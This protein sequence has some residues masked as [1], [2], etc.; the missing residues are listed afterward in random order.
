V[1]KKKLPLKALG[2]TRLP[3]LLLSMLLNFFLCHWRSR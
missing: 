3:A 1:S 2:N